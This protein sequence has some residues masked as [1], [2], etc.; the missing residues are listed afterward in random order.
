M[1]RL[2]TKGREINHID[3]HSLRRTFATDA[4]SNGAD[5]KS[6]QELLGHKTLEMTMRIYAKIRTHTKRQAVGRLSY[7]KGSQAP[8]HLVELPLNRPIR[9][10]SGEESP[11]KPKRASG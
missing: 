3:V 9:D 2:D 8:K 7:G 10:Q 6:V 11:T 5:P 1:K 4:I